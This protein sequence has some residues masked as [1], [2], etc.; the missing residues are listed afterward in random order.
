MGLLQSWVSFLRICAQ[1]LVLSLGEQQRPSRY[2]Y[3]KVVCRLLIDLT[4]DPT[5]LQA[6]IFAG[7]NPA[8]YNAGDPIRL[9]IIQVGELLVSCRRLYLA[10]TATLS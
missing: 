8:A 5:S 6:G 10:L 4:L 2:A 9:W 7:D 1:C 3:T